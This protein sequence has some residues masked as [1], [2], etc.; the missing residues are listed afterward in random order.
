MADRGQEG[1]KPSALRNMLHCDM[2]SKCLHIPMG[3]RLG[4]AC[5]VLSLQIGGPLC[6]GGALKLLPAVMGT[7]LARGILMAVPNAQGLYD[8]T[9]EH[10]ACGVGFVALGDGF[11]VDFDTF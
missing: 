11:R 2:Q 8:P 1:S 6:K 5:C 10:D 4:V 3:S 9:N 7:V